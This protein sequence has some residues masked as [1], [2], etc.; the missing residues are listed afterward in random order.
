M[1][2]QLK[3]DR[4]LLDLLGLRDVILV[5]CKFSFIIFCCNIIYVYTIQ[6]LQTIT[7]LLSDFFQ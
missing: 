3:N 5:V 4:D 1:E 2:Q 6:F 7:C